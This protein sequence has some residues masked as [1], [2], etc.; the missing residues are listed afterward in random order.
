MI[1]ACPCLG[2]Q[3]VHPSTSAVLL[4]FASFKFIRIVRQRGPLS[5]VPLCS[6]D[7][8]IIHRACRFL[9]GGHVHSKIGATKDL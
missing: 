9:R 7:H 8:L 3:A 4:N 6:R 5:V 1:E 2:V